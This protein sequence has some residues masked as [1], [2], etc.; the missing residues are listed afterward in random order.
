MMLRRYNETQQPVTDFS[1]IK[2]KN[3][4]LLKIGHFLDSIR[5][6]F[7]SI[8]RDRDG[9]DKFSKKL[10]KMGMVSR[11]YIKKLDE[12]NDLVLEAENAFYELEIE[13]KEM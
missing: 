12:F 11:S 7:D 10:D 8:L 3:Q 5:N 6:R 4:D 2:M 1:L 13:F 9:L